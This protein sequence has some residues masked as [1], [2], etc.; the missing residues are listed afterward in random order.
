MVDENDELTEA[1]RELTRTIDDLSREFE[2]Q[3]RRPPLRPPT[4]RELLA[5][6]DEVALP[7]MLAVLNSSVRTLETFQ[8]GLE[9][10]RTER[11]VRERTGEVV[12]SE[13]ANDLRKTTLSRLDTVLAELQRAASEGTLPA[14][15]RARELLTDARRL[16]DDVDD[17]LEDAAGGL[18]PDERDGSPS[19]ESVEIDIDEGS[20]G[21]DQRSVDG[22]AESN[23]DVDAELETLKDQYGPDDDPDSSSVGDDVSGDDAGNSAEQGDRS[24]DHG[25]SDDSGGENAGEHSDEDE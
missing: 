11:E 15:E 20:S 21:A 16:R 4:P 2:P 24:A 7:A 6:T 8:R 25:G 23:V 3:P 1:I 12:S 22:D 14:D 9:L 18:D 10:V 13:R 5:F 17:R 19:S